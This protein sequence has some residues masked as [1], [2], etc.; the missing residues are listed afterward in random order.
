M[1]AFAV[2]L[3]GVV[4][5]R[6]QAPAAAAAP[7][8]PPAPV[9]PLP[10]SHRQHIEGLGLDCRDC[11]LNPG[12]GKL[13][14]YPVTEICMSCHKSIPAGTASLQTLATMAASGQAIPWRRVYQLPDWVYWEHST[15]LR[16]DITCADCHGPVAERDVIARETN[17]LTMQGC[18]SCHEKRKVFMD[19]G[20][21]HEPRQ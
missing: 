3:A 5:L 13:M 16:P 10:Y 12:T 6:A 11:H 1:V 21:C 9:Q 17:V 4:S 18:V 14:T 8:I 2:L 7:R 20:D 19:C 15:H